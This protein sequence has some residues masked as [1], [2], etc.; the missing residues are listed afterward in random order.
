MRFILDVHCHTIASGHAYSTV[1]E[2]A[3]YAAGIGLEL[4]GVSDHGP[5]MQGSC[6]LYYFGNL[7]VLPDQIEGVRVLKGAEVNILDGGALDIPDALMRQLDYVIAS[8]HGLLLTRGDA[9][10]NTEAFIRAME[11]AYVSI[12]GHPGDPNYPIDT[13][14]VAEAAKRT[15]TI[16]EVN[17][18]SLTPGTFRYDGGKI[19]SKLLARC[20]AHRVPVIAGSDA[21]VDR[22]VGNLTQA[23]HMIQKSG[24]AEDLVMNTDI[25]LFLRTLEAKRQK[26]SSAPT[27][28]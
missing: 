21:H 19:L 24:I 11:N 22:H 2:N 25:D 10:Q 9:A 17:N 4:I 18:A 6:G 15:G 20:K 27:S 5:E 28:D 1:N 16:I 13:D 12:L 7:R 14:A 3:A 23:K 26:F 8:A